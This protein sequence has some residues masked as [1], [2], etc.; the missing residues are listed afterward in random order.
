[1][2]PVSPHGS[3][4]S[5]VLEDDEPSPLELEEVG[6]RPLSKQSLNGRPRSPKV[7]SEDI[8]AWDCLVGMG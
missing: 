7:S 2:V 8:K 3:C 1:M 6:S 4:I 5:I